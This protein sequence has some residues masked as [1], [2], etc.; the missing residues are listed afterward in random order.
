M[1]TLPVSPHAHA[2]EV[3]KIAKSGQQT[4]IRRY[5][6]WNKDC[7]YKLIDVKVTVQPRHG[8]ITPKFGDHLLTAA[9]VRAGDLGVCAGKSLRVAE[10]YYTS[11]AGFLGKDRFSVNVTAVQLPTVTDDYTIDVK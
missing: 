10:L 4:L 1:S 11:Q 8:E 6:A 5:F 2:A 3:L 9:D 7:S